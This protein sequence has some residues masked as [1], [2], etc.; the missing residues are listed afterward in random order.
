MKIAELNY[1]YLDT[2]SD[3]DFE[4]WQNTKTKQKVKVPIE[5]VRDFNQV[6]PL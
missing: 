3:G 6:I 4:V 2:T 1:E 5:I